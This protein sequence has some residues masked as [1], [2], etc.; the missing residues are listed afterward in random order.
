MLR[1]REGAG[2]RLVGGVH[3]SP[4]GAACAR[5]QLY[6]PASFA[7]SVALVSHQKT[8][9]RPHLNGETEGST[10]SAMVVSPHRTPAARAMAA[11]SSPAKPV[12][13]PPYGK[14][15]VTSSR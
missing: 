6:Q 5:A 15:N 2:L 13:T 4:D 12:W 14:A 7:L 8:L 9:K 1:H 3:Q 10:S 11:S